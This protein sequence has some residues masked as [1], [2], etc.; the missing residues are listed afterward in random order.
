MKKLAVVVVA[1]IFLASCEVEV[2]G[3]HTYHHHMGWEHA[4]HP[5]HHEAYN[6]GYHHDDKGAELIVR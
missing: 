4:N 2:R 5:D 3:G 1:L 6:H